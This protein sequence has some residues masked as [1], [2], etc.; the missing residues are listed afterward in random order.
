M[1]TVTRD[2][3]R[4]D[5]VLLSVTGREGLIDQWN[6]WQR[7]ES[8]IGTQFLDSNQTWIIYR[9]LSS[10]L[11]SISY[12]IFLNNQQESFWS[13]TWYVNTFFFFFFFLYDTWLAA[14]CWQLV[15]SSTWLPSA[16]S[17][18]WGLPPSNSKSW[19]HVDSITRDVFVIVT[20]QRLWWG[21]QTVKT[22]VCAI[23][24]GRS[25]QQRMMRKTAISCN[26]TV[27]G[28]C[29]GKKKQINR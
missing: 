8:K 24:N 9:C 22:A 14:Y 15:N 5:E 10:R 18:P 12:L 21:K 29:L 17:A 7:K 2:D 16:G 23:W 3:Q 27:M 20:T 28:I 25:C 19:S 26:Q 1:V 11:K 6:I 4:T 13:Q